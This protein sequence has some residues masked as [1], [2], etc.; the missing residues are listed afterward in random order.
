MTLSPTFG[1]QVGSRIESPGAGTLKKYVPLKSLKLHVISSRFW[2]VKHDDMIQDFI[3]VKGYLDD[4]DL[5]K[6][7]G[8][9]PDPKTKFTTP[10]L[11]PFRMSFSGSLSC[12]ID[13]I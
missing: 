3:F 2:G 13:C 12:K 1:D 6:K 7:G 9:E 10:W 11:K 8:E 4:Q 5:K